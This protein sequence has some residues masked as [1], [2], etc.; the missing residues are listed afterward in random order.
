MQ[1]NCMVVFF[2]FSQ[3][4]RK[5]RHWSRILSSCKF[6]KT[7]TCSSRP[8]PDDLAEKL[9]DNLRTEVRPCVQKNCENQPNKVTWK[10]AGS[11]RSSW[12][13]DVGQKKARKETFKCWTVPE[14][15]PVA[16][17]V[18][19][20][21]PWPCRNFV[22]WNLF[23]Y[24]GLCFQPLQKMGIVHRCLQWLWCVGTTCTFSATGH[25]AAFFLSVM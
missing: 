24:F 25:I 7:S 10:Q 1:M 3:I 21:A 17:V 11:I 4:Y 2:F 23:Q 20:K 6:Q 13:T 12:L 9:Q 18:G 16:I 14:I 22:L 8:K 5:E 19:D 15:L